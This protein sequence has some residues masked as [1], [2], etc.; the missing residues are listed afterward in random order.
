M[1]S[2]PA[3]ALSSWASELTSRAK[4]IRDLIG[5]K[6]W[7]SDGHH[8]EYLLKEFVKRHVDP[9]LLIGR[10]FVRPPDPEH[11]V[12]R[13]IDI[14]IVDPKIHPPWFNEGEI[15]VTAPSA[16]LAQIHVKTSLTRKELSDVI[17]SIVRTNAL[18][19][20]QL[21]SSAWSGAFFFRSLLKPKRITETIRELLL[22]S[23]TTYAVKQCRFSLTINDDQFFTI[24]LNKT[25]VVM[26]KGFQADNLSA[27]LFMADLSRSL[28]SK[29]RIGLPPFSELITRLQIKKIIEHKARKE[30]QLNGDS[31]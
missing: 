5:D 22:Q 11:A 6:H 8:K 4:R 26:T 1:D 7:L 2:E 23:A 16:V 24:E 18:I 13:E 28:T 27:A 3:G 29:H 12:S 20:S 30:E 31:N 19:P 21:R 17:S 14:L 15:I 9:S 10:G 25:G